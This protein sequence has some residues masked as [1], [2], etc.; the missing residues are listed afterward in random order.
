MFFICLVP[1]IHICLYYFLIL[2]CYFHILFLNLLATRYIL[3]FT[4]FDSISSQPAPNITE[5]KKHFIVHNEIKSVALIA[6]KTNTL[7]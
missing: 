5:I 1:Y 6:T 7:I 3:Q 4:M 2:C